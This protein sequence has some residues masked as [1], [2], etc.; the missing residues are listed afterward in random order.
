MWK[1]RNNATNE[2]NVQYSFHYISH[3]CISGAP[4][5]MTPRLPKKVWNLETR[6]LRPAAGAQTSVGAPTWRSH[7][8]TVLMR[9]EHFTTRERE[10]G[11]CTRGI[12]GRGGTKTEMQTL[13]R[14]FT[15]GVD[16]HSVIPRPRCLTGSRGEAVKYS[17]PL[18]TGGWWVTRGGWR[19]G[20]GEKP[21]Q[22]R[23]VS[24]HPFGF[25]PSRGVVP[26]DAIQPI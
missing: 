8:P 3:H 12:E 26:E 22:G 20:G 14:E 1:T 10:R 2:L 16:V 13:G 24:F 4:P 25:F 9:D 17:R 23:G 18:R 7:L 11:V 21:S 6:K 5:E 19:G 15:T